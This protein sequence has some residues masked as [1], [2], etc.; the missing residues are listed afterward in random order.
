MNPYNVSLDRGNCLFDRRQALVVSSVVAL[1]VNGKFKGHPLFEGWQLS[2]IATVRSGAPFIAGVGF[3][4][5]GLGAAFVYNRPI[6]NP[7]GTAENIKEGTLNQWFDP[8]AF[9]L[10]PVGELGNAGRNFL[11]GPHFWNR[12]FDD[13]EHQDQRNNKSAV[14]GRVLQH[15]QS[16]ELGITQCRRVRADCERR[17]S[18]QSHCGPHHN[19]GEPDAADPVC[20]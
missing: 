15:F 2:G 6:L 8:T 17:W 12:L 10:P 19:A 14:P 4:Q 16:C 13:E 7:G 9:S 20:A 5:A 11:I 3:D 18:L 1:P